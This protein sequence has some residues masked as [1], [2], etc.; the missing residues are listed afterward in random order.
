ML[1]ILIVFW[2]SINDFSVGTLQRFAGIINKEFDK[3]IPAVEYNNYFICIYLDFQHVS[4]PF[5][6]IFYS[7]N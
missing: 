6:E 1:Q 3:I 7:R 5:P 2:C 4:T